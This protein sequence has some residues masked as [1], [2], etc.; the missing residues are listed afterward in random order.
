MPTTSSYYPSR[1]GDQVIWLTNLRSKLPSHKTAL[2]YTDAEVAAMQA[3]CDRLGWALGTLQNAAQ[4]F[5]QAVTAH[6]R[7]LQIGTGVDPVA[8]PAF[9]LPAT[10]APPANVAPG[11]FKRLTNLIRNLKTRPGYTATIGQDLGVIGPEHPE[12]DPI[13][14]KPEIKLVH[15]TGGK[16]QLQWKKLGFT[17][18][19]I[20][21]DRGGGTWTFLDMDTKPHYEDPASP[22]PGAT[23]LWKYRAIYLEGDQPFGQWSDT[24][25]IAVTG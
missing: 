14:T 21:V 4:Q 2:G 25:S 19:R 23:T 12:A 11:A 9:T 5:A 6:V 1:V 16:V 7:L 20:E 15:I 24:G 10:P 18:V 8:P 3:D 22:A 17:G 13:T